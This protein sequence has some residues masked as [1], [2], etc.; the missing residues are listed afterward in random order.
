[1]NKKIL[2]SSLGVLAII[3][4]VILSPAGSSLR[5]SSIGTGD[6]NVPGVMPNRPDRRFTSEDGKNMYTL[7]Y[8]KDGSRKYSV[9]IPKEYI[10]TYTDQFGPHEQPIVWPFTD[11]P[12]EVVSNMALNQEYYS[13]ESVAKW[14]PVFFK[15]Y[16]SGN[17]TNP[18]PFEKEL[19]EAQ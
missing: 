9:E 3:G 18:G 11:F 5:S 13:A 6:T 15:N 19:T 2:L 7:T 12:R 8:N 16:S 1:M 10:D 17:D 4:V 14:A